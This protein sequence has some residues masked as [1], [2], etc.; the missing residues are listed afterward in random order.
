MKSEDEKLY[1]IA[2]VLSVFTIVYNLA[3][4][5]VSAYFGMEDEVLT[6]FGFGMDSFIETISATGIAHMIIRIMRNPHSSRDKFEITALKITGWS[7]YLLCVLLAV[8]A[9]EKILHRENPATTFWGIVISLVSISIMLV[10]I[11][12]KISLGKKL[13]SKPLIAD[14]GCAKVC[15]YMSVVLLVS[16]LLWHLFKLPYVDVAGTA[17]II[18]FS[19][20]EGRECF[21]KAKGMECCRH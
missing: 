18:Y 20:S 5:L 10:T 19:L 1:R 14:A 3:E 17:G 7:F 16:S 15:V 9:I 4:G 13:N 21:E 12:W 11:Y 2:F 6:L 8:M